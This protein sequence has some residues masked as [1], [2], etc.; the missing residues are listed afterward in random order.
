MQGWTRCNGRPT[1]GV[2]TASRDDAGTSGMSKPRMAQSAPH[3]TLHEISMES[4]EAPHRTLRQAWP[5]S[6]KKQGSRKG[7]RTFVDCTSSDDMPIGWMYRPDA[8]RRAHAPSTILPS[9]RHR[10]GVCTFPDGGRDTCS[11]GRA[12]GQP[13]GD[14]NDDRTVQIPAQFGRNV[15]LEERVGGERSMRIPPQGTL[16]ATLLRGRRRWTRC[17]NRQGPAV[18]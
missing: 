6:S 4:R 15:S 16:E 11:S 17:Q 13:T 10:P 14:A 2:R 1:D 9:G 7:P 3:Y 18:V 8:A 12:R 5:S